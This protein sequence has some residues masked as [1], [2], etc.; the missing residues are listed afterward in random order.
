MSAS[1]VQKGPKRL[2]GWQLELEAQAAVVSQQ[3]DQVEHSALASR[4]LMLWSGGQLSASAVQE[5]A[6]LAILDGASHTELGILANLGTCGSNSGNAHRD[7][8]HAF[9]Q[10]SKVAS[11]TLLQVPCV[12]PKTSKVEMVDAAVFMPHMMWSALSDCDQFDAFFATEGVPAFWDKV[13][14]TRDERLTLHP[15]F[16]ADPTAFKARTVCP[17]SCTAIKWNS[18]IETP[19]WWCLGVRFYPR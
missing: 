13:E 9:C 10:T 2:R 19:L 8:I 5:L 1:S 15:D 12:D 16:A 11:E 3:E 18:K 4:L 7:L 14:A 6:H 17:C